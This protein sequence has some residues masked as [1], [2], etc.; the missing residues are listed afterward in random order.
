MATFKV[1]MNKAKPKLFKNFKRQVDTTNL[2][3]AN[4]QLNNNSKQHMQPNVVPNHQ[5]SQS[6]PTLPQSLQQHPPIQNQR[7]ASHQ[8]LNKINIKP[9]YSQGIV[10][11]PRRPAGV[12][13]A[14]AHQE[15]HV[16]TQP[17]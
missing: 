5:S 13:H 8:K 17:Q 16:V 10:P 12:Q 4:Q 15:Q 6:I 1:E 14:E 3:S 7:Q 2:S 11:L 9:T